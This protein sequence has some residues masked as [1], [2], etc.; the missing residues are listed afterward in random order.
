MRPIG[1]RFFALAASAFFACGLS[2]GGVRTRA[3]NG[4]ATPSYDEEEIL[5]PVWSG[6]VS[7]DESVLVVENEEGGIDPIALLYDATEILSVRSASYLVAYEEG[8]DYSLENGRLVIR[9]DGNIPRLTYAEFHPETGT[10]GFESKDGGYVLWKEGSWFHERQI[11]VTYRHAEGYGEYIPEGKGALLPKT[12]EKLLRKENLKILVYGDSISTG[13]NSSGHEAIHVP[14]YMPIYPELFAMGIEKKYGVEVEVV[15]ESRGGMDS[16][17]G[18]SNLRGGILDQYPDAGFDLA[19]IAFGMN[20]TTKDKESLALNESRIAK[21]L[22][23]RYPDVEILYVATMLPNEDAYKFYGNQ[24]TFYEGLLAYETEGSVA[25]NVG[26]VHAGLLGRKRYAD[27][28]GNNVNHA[29]DYLARVYAQTLLRTL[30]VTDYG[31][32]EPP[33]ESVESG[34]S[35]SAGGTESISGTGASSAGGSSCGAAAGASAAGIGCLAVLPVLA[36]RRKGGREAERAENQ[37]GK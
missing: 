27:M 6:S 11:I 19:I 32:E 26:G 33:Q 34:E 9:K 16:N 10:D 25:V 14:P 29:N 17:W 5:S 4:T 23:T 8:R 7:Y 31:R 21:G 3:E 24:Y 28:T 13:G 35:A 12:T 30:E 22:R 20:D 15:N 18:L 36:K 37:R 2:V 1:K